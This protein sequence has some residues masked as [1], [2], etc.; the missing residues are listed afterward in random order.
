MVMRQVSIRDMQ[1]QDIPFIIDIE[2]MSFSTPWSETSFLNEIYKPRSVAK[3]VISDERVVGYACIELVAD[4]GHILN[5]AVHPD[6]RKT[7]IAASLVEKIIEESKLRACRLL[8]LEVRASNYIAK[9]LYEGF[10]FKIVGVRKKYYVAPEEDAV[11]MLLE[12]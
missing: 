1:E 11:I 10:G 5:M 9:K 8:Y 2:R 4:E 7:G 6:Y 3:V 12:I